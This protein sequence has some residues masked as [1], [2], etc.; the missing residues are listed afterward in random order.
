MCLLTDRCYHCHYSAVSLFY[1]EHQTR[2][3][4]DNKLFSPEAFFLYFIGS[5]KTLRIL[6]SI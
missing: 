6:L 2:P 4:D 3:V 5:T 1:L